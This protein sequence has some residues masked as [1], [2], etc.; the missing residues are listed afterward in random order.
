MPMIYAINYL[1]FFKVDVINGVLNAKMMKKMTQL[2]MG[3]QI[4]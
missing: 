1:K 4:L 3:C 2:D